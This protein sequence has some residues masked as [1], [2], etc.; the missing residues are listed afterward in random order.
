LYAECPIKPPRAIERRKKSINERSFRFIVF[1]RRRRRVLSINRSTSTAAGY[2]VVRNSY[3]AVKKHWLAFV[4]LSQRRRVRFHGRKAIRTSAIKTAGPARPGPAGGSAGS[5]GE[6]FR[7]VHATP[8]ATRD[9]AW[10]RRRRFGTIYRKVAGPYTRVMEL[11]EP[12]L[13]YSRRHKSS[14][15]APPDDDD[16][17]DGPAVHYATSTSFEQ[18]PYYATVLFI[19]GLRMGLSRNALAA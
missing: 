6:T 3:L 18:R 19:T 5:A 12:G 10:Q 8:T 13:L 9:V 17:D 11:D 4:A 16:D 1:S 14:S 2:N 7:S 15:A